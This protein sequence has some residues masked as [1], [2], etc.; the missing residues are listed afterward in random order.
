[1][2]TDTHATPLLRRTLRGGRSAPRPRLQLLTLWGVR[3]LLG[4]VCVLWAAVTVT[5]FV[6]AVLPG[7]RAAIIYNQATGHDVVPSSSVLA[8]INKQ[9]GFDES[10]LTQYWDYMKGAVHGNLGTSYT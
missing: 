8:P 6:Q 4:A 7:S 2:G 1:M 9:Y 3:R 10:L 5:F